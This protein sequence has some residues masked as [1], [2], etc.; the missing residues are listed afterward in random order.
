M[1]ICHCDW[2]SKEADWPTAGQ[3]EV[4]QDLQAKRV[5]KEKQV[6][7]S[8]L[9]GDAEKRRLAILRKGIKQ[10]IRVYLRDMS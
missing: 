3:V 5:H 9:Q 8:E 7:F 6:G 2:F 1:N 4:R 10:C